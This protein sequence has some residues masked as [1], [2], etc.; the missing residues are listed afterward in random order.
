[1]P[2]VTFPDIA[3]A[4]FNQIRQH[5][6]SS[7]AVTI[8]LLET[9]AVISSAARRAE[10]QAALRLHARMIFRGACEALPEET[11]LKEVEERYLSVGR[12]MCEPLA[13]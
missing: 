12:S 6:R 3:N 13:P 7:A 5:A 8:R 4:A 11:D 10:D 9:I 2:A 1:V